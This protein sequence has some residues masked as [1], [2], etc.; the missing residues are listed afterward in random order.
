[1]DFRRIGDRQGK[2]VARLL[3]LFR[4]CIFAPNF[5]RAPKCGG[6]SKIPGCL[7]FPAFRQSDCALPD[8]FHFTIG[9]HHGCAQCAV[10][11]RAL[12][13]QI[14]E[15]RESRNLA[16]KSTQNLGPRLSVLQRLSTE[17]FPARSG[18]WLCRRLRAK[19]KELRYERHTDDRRHF[20]A[21]QPHEHGA[22]AQAGGS[23]TSEGAT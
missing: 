7:D 20:A 2:S 10:I 12:Q 23:A 13:W 18:I 1:L 21:N 14:R 17:R 22:C 16:F 4:L 19:A 6:G 3:L 8:Y 15:R 5:V 11:E 9:V